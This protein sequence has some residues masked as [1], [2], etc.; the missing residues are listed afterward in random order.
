MMS[1]IF[2]RKIA[3]IWYWWLNLWLIIIYNPL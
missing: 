1:S 3:L 2:H